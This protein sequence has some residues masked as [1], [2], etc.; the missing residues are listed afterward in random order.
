[1]RCCN[2]ARSEISK[3]RFG[4]SASE[5]NMPRK[6]FKSDRLLMLDENLSVVAVP[7]RRSQRRKITHR[8]KAPRH[9]WVATEIG[10][11]PPQSDSIMRLRRLL[12]AALR[13]WE[14]KNGIRDYY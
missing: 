1:V 9:F 3:P 7:Q 13:V 6:A 10:E 14:L 5:A 12:M 2:L 8:L 4:K 11:P